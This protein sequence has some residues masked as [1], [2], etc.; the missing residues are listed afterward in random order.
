ML[1]SQCFRSNDCESHGH[2]LTVVTIISIADQSSHLFHLAWQSYSVKAQRRA[3]RTPCTRSVA[4]RRARRFGPNDRCI[5][6]GKRRLRSHGGKLVKVESRVKILRKVAA[7]STP[8]ASCRIAEKAEKQAETG[9]HE[10]LSTRRVRT[11]RAAITVLAL[12]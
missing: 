9:C 5:D 3:S 4:I 1:A 12:G 6:R 2:G 11:S 8:S 7:E 10:S